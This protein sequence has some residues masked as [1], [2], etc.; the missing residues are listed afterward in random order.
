MEIKK[1][2][3]YHL[4]IPL[5]AHYHMSGGRVMKHVDTTI[6]KITTKSGITGWGESCPWGPNYLPGHG[7][8]S[9]LA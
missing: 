6:V 9:G 3:V 4:D 1:I 5:T 7:K 2:D 8:G